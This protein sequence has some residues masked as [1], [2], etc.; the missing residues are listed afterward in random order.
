ALQAR[1]LGTVR[2]GGGE[3][4]GPAL[5]VH[6]DGDAGEW[7]TAPGARIV[8]A[9]RIEVD[10]VVLD[11]FGDVP[12][13][14]AGVR[15]LSMSTRCCDRGEQS[16]EQRNDPDADDGDRDQQLDEA[17]AR[18]GALTSRGAAVHGPITASDPGLPDATMYLPITHPE[19]APCELP[20][21]RVIG[22]A[23]GA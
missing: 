16:R 19:N 15:L 7:D 14:G 3:A 6:G 22:F 8:A 11:G 10:R 17:L 18:L 5:A 13:H 2:P 21:A 12:G 23:V 1:A 20:V 4:S 9:I